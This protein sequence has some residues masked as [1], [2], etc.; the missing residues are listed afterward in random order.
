MKEFT[1]TITGRGRGLPFSKGILSQSLL[2]AAIEPN[3]AFDVARDI[4]R[5]LVRRIDGDAHMTSD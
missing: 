3:D 2:A 5:D 4:E 1:I